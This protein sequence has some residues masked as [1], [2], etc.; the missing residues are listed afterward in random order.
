M[1]EGDKEGLSEKKTEREGSRQ[2]GRP[3]EG[4]GKK[5]VGQSERD[6]DRERYGQRARG[7]S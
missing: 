7:E 3:V 2:R 1:E 5:G 4:G 6:E